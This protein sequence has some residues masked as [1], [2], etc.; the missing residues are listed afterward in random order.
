[1]Q[2]KIYPPLS[3]YNFD[4]T[5][6]I[7]DE[8]FDMVAAFD[9]IEH[10]EKDYKAISNI[11][12]MLNKNGS[13]IISVPQ[14]MF[15]WSRLDE[16][17]KHKRRY[18]KEGL[19]KLLT[20]IKFEVVYSTSFVFT[21]FPLMLIS[22]IFDKNQSNKKSIEQSLEKR[23]KFSSISNKLLGIFMRVDE[24][25]IKLGLSL[26]FGGTLIVVAKKC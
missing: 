9:V 4:A 25:L 24:I 15:L 11:N 3:S 5:H 14:H 22:R 8:K 23:V 2:K 1:M 17:V 19:S 18:S 7:I 20:D 13:L 16:I 12:N 6:G 26:P 10:I 21:L